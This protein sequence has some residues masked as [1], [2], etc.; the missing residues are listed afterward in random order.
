MM[1][2]HHAR[3]SNRWKIVDVFIPASLSEKQIAGRIEDQ[4]RVTAGEAGDFIA[5]VHVGGGMR[6]GSH[7]RYRAAY[8]PGP[9]GL[10]V[11]VDCTPAF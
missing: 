9:P 8:L 10:L 6:T 11:D 7:L 3:S 5:A 4:L 2:A 1:T